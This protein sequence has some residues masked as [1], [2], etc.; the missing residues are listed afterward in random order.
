MIQI[1]QQIKD[2]AVRELLFKLFA[3][4]FL[5]SWLSPNDQS[6]DKSHAMPRQGRRRGEEE[7]EDGEDAGYVSRSSVLG[8]GNPS[9]SSSSSNIRSSSGSRSTPTLRKRSPNFTSPPSSRGNG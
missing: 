9:P 7:E 4:H 5:L 1:L 8:M 2:I 6:S 3:H